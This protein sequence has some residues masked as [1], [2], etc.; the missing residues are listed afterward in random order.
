MRPNCPLCNSIQ[1]KLTSQNSIFYH[2]A[3][4]SVKIV[5]MI[6]YL[7]IRKRKA[8]VYGQWLNSLLALYS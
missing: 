3:I 8:G 7:N 6:S 1:T 2:L 4:I 5:V